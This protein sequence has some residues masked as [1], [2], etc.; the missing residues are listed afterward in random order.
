MNLPT[1]FSLRFK[2]VIAGLEFISEVDCE[3]TTAARAQ[4][5]AVQN[6]EQDIELVA[7][8]IGLQLG[9]P[10]NGGCYLMDEDSEK[11]FVNL[12][13]ELQ[14]GAEHFFN[15]RLG[16]YDKFNNAVTPADLGIVFPDGT[17]RVVWKEEHAAKDF[18]TSLELVKGTVELLLQ[19]QEVRYFQQSDD[20]LE[21]DDFASLASRRLELLFRAGLWPSVDGEYEPDTA[22]TTAR[23]L[24]AEYSERIVA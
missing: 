5:Q 19:A 10:N 13:N 24:L 18:D 20:E 8:L 17:L 21:N 3:D 15:E 1:F 12:L 9:K 4:F 16:S 14:L 11:I 22:Q 2:T 6:Q 7:V 23:T